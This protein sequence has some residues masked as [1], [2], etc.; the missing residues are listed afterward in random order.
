VAKTEQ[1][2]QHKRRTEEE[3]RVALAILES[4][5]EQLRIHSDDEHDVVL[6]DAVAELLALRQISVRLIQ[7]I[8]SAY[9]EANAAL[10][11]I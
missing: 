1:K 2:K 6:A 11:N 8:D 9:Q 7:H 10:K 4:K 3:M 5:K